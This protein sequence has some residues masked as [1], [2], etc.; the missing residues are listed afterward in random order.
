MRPGGRSCT[1]RMASSAP[2]TNASRLVVSWRIVSVWPRAPK[3]DLLVGDQARQA[4]ASGSPDA[5]RPRP[6]IRSAVWRRGAARAVDLRRVVLL[7]DR[8]V[9]H[10]LGRGGREAHH[11]HGARR[12]SSATWNRRHAV[13]GRAARRAPPTASSERP[14][15]PATTA[16]PRSSARR[17]FS[18]TDSGP[19]DVDQHV[20]LA[21]RERRLERAR[22]RRSRRRRASAP[23]GRRA[24]GRPRPRCRRRWARRAGRWHRRRRRGSHASPAQQG[25]EPRGEHRLVRADARRPRGAPARTAR[26]PAARCRRP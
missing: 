13:L 15:A 3:H 24:S 4:D 1:R 8:G 20:D 5:A 9:G 14:V 19:R 7:D 2:G 18:S 10:V 6:R 23:R 11:Q 22:T 21:R 12:R 17:T 25:V 16:M 26:R